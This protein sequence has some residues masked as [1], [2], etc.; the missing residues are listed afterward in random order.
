M[1][2]HSEQS[3]TVRIIPKHLSELTEINDIFIC[4]FLFYKN[5]QIAQQVIFI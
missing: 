1:K 5:I 3:Q 4:N 2:L